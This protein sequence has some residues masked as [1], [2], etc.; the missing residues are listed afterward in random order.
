MSL[1]KTITDS[2]Y[3]SGVLKK[4]IFLGT[5]FF[6]MDG[7]CSFRIKQ[8]DENS[9]R[10]VDSTRR[11][12]IILS[13]PSFVG[14]KI[15]GY[16]YCGDL[17][18]EFC[19]IIEENHGVGSRVMEFPSEVRIIKARESARF[20]SND[21]IG[22]SYNVTFTSQDKGFVGVVKLQ[23]HSP[24]GFGGI[25]EFNSHF[26]FAI[27]IGSFCSG[28][29]RTVAGDVPLYGKIQWIKKSLDGKIN[30]GASR[31]IYAS[32]K[33]NTRAE[34]VHATLQVSCI[35]PLNSHQTHY[36][37]VENISHTGAL[38]KPDHPSAIRWFIPELTFYLGSPKILAKVV[39]YY[40]GR[41]RV[42]FVGAEIKELIKL[43]KIVARLRF[44]SFQHYSPDGID[45][46][47]L[48]T[49]SGSMS[50]S[51]ASISAPLRERFIRDHRSLDQDTPWLFKWYDVDEMENLRG[52]SM[53]CY[54]GDSSWYVGGIAGHIDSDISI[55]EN[56][57]PGQMAHFREF[58]KEYCI[59]HILVFNWTCE[60]PSWREWDNRLDEL[61][62]DNLAA[63]YLGWKLFFKPIDQ[64]DIDRKTRELTNEELEKIKKLSGWDPGIRDFFERAVN[65]SRGNAID[66]LWN[67][68]SKQSSI[69]NI[70]RCCDYNGGMVVISST[71]YP[72]AVHASGAIN[73][74]LVFVIGNL[75]EP[76]DLDLNSLVCSFLNSESIQSTGFYLFW[77][78]G[79]YEDFP[80]KMGGT[81]SSAEKIIWSAGSY[82][83]LD[84]WVEK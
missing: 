8:I 52:T 74:P 83:L 70:L 41:I 53:I 12:R 13:D 37:V 36:F 72:D 31:P 73:F 50:S 38:L 35:S 6:S 46:V 3:I 44:P 39:G 5:E 24:E 11:I 54:Y 82:H 79:G 47:D 48:M 9:T 71:V 56:F 20:S 14:G 78:M 61:K 75:P 28:K 80:I 58:V 63:R 10:G 18:I 23:D 22:S 17:R 26:D 16:G 32:E 29:I 77:Y 7:G 76:T 40:D 43:S 30:F 64:L 57:I 66:P 69:R 27:L 84:I 67:S 68:D 25:V 2:R 62:R 21:F 34:R 81:Y 42:N 33:K 60:H 15:S 1:Q 45:L 55:K 59:N 65:R 4:T 49:A 51:T 19:T